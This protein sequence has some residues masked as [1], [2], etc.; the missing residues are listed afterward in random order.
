MFEERS[1]NRI[2]CYGCPL[3]VS[4]LLDKRYIKLGL[5]YLALALLFHCHCLVILVLV[6]QPLFPDLTSLP[7]MLIANSNCNM[8]PAGYRQPDSQMFGGCHCHCR[9]QLA[10][11]P[12]F[13]W[14]AG[15]QEVPL[16]LLD[17][18]SKREYI[19]QIFYNYL[20]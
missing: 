12:W 9:C 11:T 17:Y 13:V 5:V 1:V 3:T 15:K 10:L 14:L 16:G 8:A 2:V 20:A 19:D 6:I 18:T 7:Q 4:R